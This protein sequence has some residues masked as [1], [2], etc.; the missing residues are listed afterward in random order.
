M[1]K[2]KNKSVAVTSLSLPRRA[3]QW[4]W[5]LSAIFRST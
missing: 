4:L 3:P 1:N 2:T 5:V